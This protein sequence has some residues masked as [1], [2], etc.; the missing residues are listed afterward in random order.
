M[1]LLDGL[2]DLVGQPR[3]NKPG[4]DDGHLDPM[5]HDLTAERP[6]E[7]AQAKFCGGVDG[8]CR[9]RDIT[10]DRIDENDQS[11]SALDHRRQQMARQR[12]RGQQVRPDQ[13]GYNFVREI[14]Y[15]P[16]IYRLPISL[17]LQRRY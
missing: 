8:S 16:A 15:R 11:A 4:R 5:L 12:D 1:E 2:V 13:L 3:R 17:T 6:G 10:A 7:P 9:Q 14:R